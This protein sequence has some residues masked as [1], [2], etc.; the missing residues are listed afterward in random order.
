MAWNGDGRLVTSSRSAKPIMLLPV[1]LL[2]DI[3]QASQMVKAVQ[4]APKI[5]TAA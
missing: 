4:Q 3:R 5:S 2:P 1:Q